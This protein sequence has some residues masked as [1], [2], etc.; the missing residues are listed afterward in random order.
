MNYEKIYHQLIEKRQQFP[1][2]YKKDYSIENH[3]IIPRSI[4]GT[5]DQKNLVYLTCREHFIAHLLLVK[6]AIQKNDVRMLQK[7]I[8]A[9]LFLVNGRAA[10]K[11]P[12]KRMNSRQYEW[13]KLHQ[14]NVWIGRHHTDESRMKI[15]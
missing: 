9:V 15:R 5:D 6:I 12:H 2:E 7:M 13:L 4:Y 14:E 11:S 3:H 1:L 10:T 8:R